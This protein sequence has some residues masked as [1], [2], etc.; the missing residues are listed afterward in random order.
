M[1]SLSE[2]ELKNLTEALTQNATKGIDPEIYNLYGAIDDL[3]KSQKYKDVLNSPITISKIYEIHNAEMGEKRKQEKATKYSKD[4]FEYL[5]EN[6]NVDLNVE[7]VA[8]IRVILAGV[9]EK[10]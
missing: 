9:N 3:R 5:K 10:E 8:Q 4:L 2:I 7:Y 6:K 1:S